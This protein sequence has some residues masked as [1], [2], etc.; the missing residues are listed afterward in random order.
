MHCTS[1][2]GR[3][4]LLCS[5]VILYRSG[6]AS[7]LVSLNSRLQNLKFAGNFGAGHFLF[8]Y[9]FH[10]EELSIFCGTGGYGLGLVPEWI[11]SD[12]GTKCGVRHLVRMGQLIPYGRFIWSAELCE[13]GLIFLREG[14][15]SE[16]KSLDLFLGTKIGETWSF[17]YFCLLRAINKDN[18]LKIFDSLWFSLRVWST[19]IR[20]QWFDQSCTILLI[21][22]LS[23]S[24]HLFEWSNYEFHYV[25]N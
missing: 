7:R 8:F 20:S 12:C 18:H 5:G 19:H 3:A 9:F 6:R 15:F 24:Y 13:F 2:P 14:C 11:A 25:M 21:F 4:A 10:S 17:F 16:L 22:T 23:R 1:L